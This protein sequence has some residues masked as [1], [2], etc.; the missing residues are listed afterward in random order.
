MTLIGQLP[1]LKNDKTKII[2]SG[3][4][5]VN[6]AA[7]REILSSTCRNVCEQSPPIIAIANYFYFQLSMFRNICS[8]FNK[9][10][11]FKAV[12]FIKHDMI[13]S[14]ANFQKIAFIGFILTRNLVLATY[15]N[16]YQVVFRSWSRLNPKFPACLF[17]P[18]GRSA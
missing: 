14:I 1:L 12:L 9:Q 4:S 13:C 16:S 11:I 8:S 6:G 10:S 5:A 7:L 17:N 18:F 3:K 15:E 2:T